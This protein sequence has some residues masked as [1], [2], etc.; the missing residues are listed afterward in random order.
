M[1]P[2]KKIPLGKGSHDVVAIDEFLPS[3][4]LER[5]DEHREKVRDELPEGHSTSDACAETDLQSPTLL[6]KVDQAPVRLLKGTL[7][8]GS[9]GDFLPSLTI[10]A[11]EILPTLK[12]SLSFL[13]FP[14]D[15][16]STQ[17]LQGA[18]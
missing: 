14:K 1:E 4:L 10:N 12:T 15:F 17:R 11:N 9:S 7:L 18:E 5:I 3:V 13:S 8:K 6:E 2:G 16:M